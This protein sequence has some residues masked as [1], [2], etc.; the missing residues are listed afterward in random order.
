MTREPVVLI[1]AEEPS[2]VPSL[3]RPKS[4]SKS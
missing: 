1:A 2:E 4:Y 3:A